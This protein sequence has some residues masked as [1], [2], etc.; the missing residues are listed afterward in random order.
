[1]K[2]KIFAVSIVGMIM[3]AGLGIFSIEAAPPGP[4]I[5]DVAIAVNS[6][7]AFAGSF[8]TLIAAVL[9]ANPA[10]VETLTGNGQFTVFA[11]TD[12]AF[13]ALGLDETNI[14][15]LPQGDLTNIL[16]Y[17]VARGR[18]YSDDILASER[19]RVLYRGNRKPGFLMQSSGVL[20]DALGNTANIIVTDVEAANGIIHAIDNVVLPYAP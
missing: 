20:T 14:G 3:L 13:A 17:H 5:V 16:L 1:M 7:G 2:S 9:A 8:D 12:D 4:T 15:T 18:R 6:E 19:I 10:V 11:P